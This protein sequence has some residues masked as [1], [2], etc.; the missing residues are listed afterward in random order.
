MLYRS[1]TRPGT[2][3]PGRR[4][5]PPVNVSALPRP[6]I[7]TTLPK[8]TPHAAAHFLTCGFRFLPGPLLFAAHTGACPTRAF[9]TT[10]PFVPRACPAINAA[11]VVAH[12]NNPS[13]TITSTPRPP[14]TQTYYPPEHPGRGF[15]AHGESCR[16]TGRPRPLTSCSG[17]QEEAASPDAFSPVPPPQLALPAEPAVSRRVSAA[18]LHRTTGRSRPRV[19]PQPGCRQRRCRAAPPSQ[20]HDVKGGQGELHLRD[21][22]RASQAAHGRRGQPSLEDPERARSHRPPGTRLRPR[23][24]SSPVRVC[25]DEEVPRLIPRSASPTPT[26]S[27]AR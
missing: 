2:S 24:Q 16:G 21:R 17:G 18:S 23:A 5:N 13:A 20:A 26:V 25:R 1:P 27:I 12:G 8:R 7:R 22:V 4:P 9:T 19:D 6:L 10:P 11:A 15:S 14:D 3:R